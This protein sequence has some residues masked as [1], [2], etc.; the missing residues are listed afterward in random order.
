MFK[1]IIKFFQIFFKKKDENEQGVVCELENG[2]SR[3]RGVIIDS[4]DYDEYEEPEIINHDGE[5]TLF[6]LDDIPDSLTLY[7]IDFSNIKRR[8]KKNVDKDFKIVKCVG[9]TAGFKAHKFIN[10]EHNKIDYAILDITLG[11]IKKLNNGEYLEFDGVDIAIDILE[12]NPD[13]KILFSTAHTLNKRNPTMKYYFEKFENNTGK[14][15]EDH[16]LHKNSERVT[17]IKGLLYGGS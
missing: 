15:I 8:F 7:R 17:P 13:A 5:K 4:I 6:I 1:S 12:D 14:K 16:Y 11:Y 2:P 9:A 3:P 10:V